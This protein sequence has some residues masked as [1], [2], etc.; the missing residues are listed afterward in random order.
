MEWALVRKAQHLD[1]AEWALV[2][3]AQYID[4]AEW[5]LVRTLMQWSGPWNV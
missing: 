5:A 4:A 2:H 3:L 1:A